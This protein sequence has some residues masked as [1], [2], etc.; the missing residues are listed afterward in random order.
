[1]YWTGHVLSIFVR[2]KPSEAVVEIDEV[3]AVPGKGLHGDHHFSGRSFKEN[4]PGRELTLIEHEAL[5]AIEKEHNVSLN[6]GESRRNIITEN[7]PLNHLIGKEFRVGEVTLK[8]IRLC[9]PCSHLGEL[10]QKEVLPALI[11]RGGLR[12]QILTKGNICAGDQVY[13]E[14][15]EPAKEAPHAGTDQRS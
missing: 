15:N 2:S 13:V 4:D 5:T 14:N 12:A 3:L 6:P 7:V 9:E 11:H 1:M 8:G 10:T